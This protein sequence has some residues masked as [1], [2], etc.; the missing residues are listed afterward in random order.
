MEILPLRV[1]E[2]AVP[3][4]SL[5]GV[6]TVAHGEAETQ[7]VHGPLGIGELIDRGRNNPDSTF[8]EL[9]EVLL[10]VSQ[11]LT[12]DRSPMATVGEKYC[13]RLRRKAQG[14]SIHEA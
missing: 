5:P 13:L 14:A 3:L 2:H 9:A 8:L 1:V 10:K 11:L 6:K 4:C 12:A 7:I